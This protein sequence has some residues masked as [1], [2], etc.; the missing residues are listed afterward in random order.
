MF[1]NYSQDVPQVINEFLIIV[2]N[3][4]SLYAISFAQT[5]PPW[6]VKGGGIPSSHKN[7]YFLGSL[8]SFCFFFFFFSFLFQMGQ[9][10]WLTTP[11]KHNLRGGP[12]N[13]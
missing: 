13:E 2:P 12:S 3:N 8:Q 10:K 6:C 9:S 5:S 7:G 1:P 4:T 11:Q